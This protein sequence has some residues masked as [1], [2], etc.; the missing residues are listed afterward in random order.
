MNKIKLSKS[1]IKNRVQ[2]WYSKWCNSCMHDE[3]QIYWN[4]Y[5]GYQDLYDYFD[6]SSMFEE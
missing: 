6:K 2:Y 3:R 4:L 1:E 5:K